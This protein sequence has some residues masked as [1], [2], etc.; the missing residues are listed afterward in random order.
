M[1]GL[2]ARPIEADSRIQIS[3]AADGPWLLPPRRG[4]AYKAM[5]ADE[6]ARGYALAQRVLRLDH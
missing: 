2:S 6:R 5:T 1:P 4:L 3:A